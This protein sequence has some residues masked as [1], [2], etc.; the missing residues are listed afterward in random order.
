MA[1]SEHDQILP[2]ANGAAIDLFRTLLRLYK[3]LSSRLRDLLA[4]YQ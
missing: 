4:Y 2:G 3:D 1:R